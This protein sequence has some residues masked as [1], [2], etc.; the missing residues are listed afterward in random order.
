MGAGIFSSPNP[1]TGIMETPA[2]VAAE[3]LMKFLLEIGCFLFVAIIDFFEVLN[4]ITNISR[5]A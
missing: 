5:R 1:L 2:V 3:T 4:K